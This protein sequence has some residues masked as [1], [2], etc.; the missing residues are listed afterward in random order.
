MGECEI[1][2]IPN[3]DDAN[4][5]KDGGQ[6]SREEW[7]R[8][9]FTQ[10]FGTSAEELHAQG[11]DARQYAIDHR[12]NIRQFAQMQRRQGIAVPMGRPS[13]NRDPANSGPNGG[14]PT[15]QGRGFG[16]ASRFG[17]GRRGGTAWIGVL[18]AL[19]ALRFLLVD[20]FAGTHAAIFWVLCIG[21][22]LLVARVILFSWLRQRRFNRRSTSRQRNGQERV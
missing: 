4:L 18:I 1:N 2:S 12:Q 8:A 5:A 15:N 3:N 22:I 19:F 10:I 6:Q 7:V 13:G 20:S 16:G 11:I 14:R 21:G 9:H 17:M